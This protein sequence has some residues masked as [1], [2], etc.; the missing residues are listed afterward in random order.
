MV[1]PTP[2]HKNVRLYTGTTEEKGFVAEVRIPKFVGG[3][4]DMII[5]GSRAFKR[6]G[7]VHTDM[8]WKYLECFVYVVPEVVS[9]G[10]KKDG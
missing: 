10:R 2:F 6:S 3:D 7:A 1:D 4:P 9:D 5:W 8:E